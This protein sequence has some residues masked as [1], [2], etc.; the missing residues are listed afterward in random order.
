MAS[1][2]SQLIEEDTALAQSDS[3]EDAREIC[4]DGTYFPNNLRIISLLNQEEQMIWLILQP[5]KVSV[6]VSYIR[7]K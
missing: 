5:R 6:A 3:L 1:A 7:Q 2:A 4:A